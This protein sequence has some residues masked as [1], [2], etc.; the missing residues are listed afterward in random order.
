MNPFLL[1]HYLYD[2]FY[3]DPDK[4][5]VTDGGRS[6]SYRELSFSS[7]SVAHCLQTMGVIRQDRVALFLQRSVDCVISIL[8]ILKADAIYVPI[9]QKVPGERLVFILGDAAPK[10]LI[11][12]SKTIS[13]THVALHSIGV[14]IPIL[15]LGNESRIPEGIPGKCLDLEK[16][17]SFDRI[18]PSYLNGEDDIAYILY[19]SGSTGRP[20]GV[21][22]SHRNVKGYIDWAI[23]HFNI[24][25]ADNILGTAPFHFDMSTFD[26][27]C[28]LKAGATLC[29]VDESTLLFPAKLVNFIER[30]QVTLWK[31]VASLL[32]YMSR[33][34][35]LKAGAMPTLRQVL[36]AG[37]TLPT[38]YL[39]DWMTNFPEKTFYNAY[40]PT[41]ATG[42]S[43]CYQID[44]LPA[45]AHVRIPIGMPRHGTR[46]LLLADNHTEVL[47]GEV[48]EI[49][50]AGN[51]LAKGYLNNPEKTAS[52]FVQSP[53]ILD[54][55]RFYKTGDLGRR[56]PDGNLEYLGRKD[57]QLKFMGYRIEAGEIEQ[58]LLSIPWVKD[59]A[60]DLLESKLGYGVLEL[61]AFWEA[62][63]EIDVLTI[64]AELKK[65]LPGYMI[66]K[67]FIRVEKMPRCDRGKI[68]LDALKENYQ[69][70]E[71]GQH[72]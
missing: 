14:T 22:I 1:Q 18:E 41:E 12:D 52:A 8:G 10:V 19:T 29:V 34:G 15:L 67:R 66:P 6:I 27:Y 3:R 47:L 64:S 62:E 53:L 36:F 50:I 71:W 32:M 44:C 35:A 5:A 70:Y 11:C 63:G 59:A 57:R 46:T 2:S 55:E 72:G 38:K 31:G 37:E 24:T 60:V 33:G 17:S 20:K 43:T 16:E 68:K 42:V 61:V 28:A 49:C 56:L 48:G 13:A 51:G 54:G 26:I 40:G 25:A 4:T 23:G 21:M 7:N 69:G 45:W 65:L 30:Q 58:V 39:I 9:D